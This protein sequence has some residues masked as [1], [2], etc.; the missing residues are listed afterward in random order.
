M[1]GVL[2]PWTRLRT[3]TGN[4]WLMLPYWWSPVLL[5]IIGIPLV[6]K[7]LSLLFII[8]FLLLWS[9][10]GKD[11]IFVSDVM[12]DEVKVWILKRGIQQPGYIINIFPPRE[13]SRDVFLRVC[14]WVPTLSLTFLVIVMILSSMMTCLFSLAFP[15]RL[16]GRS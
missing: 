16:Y 14:T 12:E 1:S 11:N 2:S 10:W 7:E 3:S 4:V 6:R 5:K 9:P 13:L 8:G 15:D